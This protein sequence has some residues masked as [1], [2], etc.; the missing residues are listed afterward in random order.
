M[1]DFKRRQVSGPKLLGEILKET[2][3]RQKLTLEQAEEETKVRAKYLEALEK[4]AYDS[5][6]DSV[7]T[8]G[9]LTKYVD[10]LGLNQEKMLEKFKQERGAAKKLSR[11]APEKKI[12]EQF[13]LITPKIMTIGIIIALILAV[14]AYFVYSINRFTSPPNL[15]ISSP[16][17][18][19]VILTDEVS[20]VG[21][22]DE[23]VALTINNQAVSVSENGNFTQPVKL[24]VGLNYFEVKAINQLKKENVKIIKVLAE[25]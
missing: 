11:L 13:F 20:I 9:F 4:G 15:E 2:R 16:L 10:F 18:E 6:P 8:T 12:K 21:K 5:L 1:P 23:G 25:Y 14:A 19:Q 3:K 7:Y 24:S 22:T 17:A